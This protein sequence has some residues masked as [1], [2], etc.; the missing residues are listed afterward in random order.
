M[1]GKMIS[2]RPLRI[3]SCACIALIVGACKTTAPEPSWDG[4]ELREQKKLDAVYV[5]P[6][7]PFKAYQQVMIAPV[8]V[9][10]SKDWDPNRDSAQ[11]LPSFNK[12]DIQ[13]IK[14]GIATEFKKV[15]E[16][17]LTEGGYKIATSPGDD[18]LHV[19]AAIIDL[20]ITAPEDMTAGRSRTYTTDSGRMTLVMELK[21]STSGEVLARVVDKEEGRDFGTLT[22]TNRVTNL[23]DLR[24]AL[25]KWATALRT[26]LDRVNGKTA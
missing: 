10:F 1:I 3:L 23:S 4:L 12:E 2:I 17:T 5:K 7:V 21:D 25:K 18:V 26:G 19:G 9:A 15:F 13:A 22:W 14:D 16:E 20:Y 24:M 8:Q 11:R 6:N